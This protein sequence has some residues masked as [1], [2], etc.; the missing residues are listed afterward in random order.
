MGTD[1]LPPGSRSRGARWFD[2]TTRMP[3][4]I[5][6]EGILQLAAPFDLHHGGVLPSVRFAWRMVGPSSA[7]VIVALGGISGQIGRAHV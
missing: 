7:P 6:Q 1:E 2:Q 4:H 5:D 3:E